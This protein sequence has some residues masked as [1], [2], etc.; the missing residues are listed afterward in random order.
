MADTF[1]PATGRKIPQ[2]PVVTKSVEFT[3]PSNTT[4]YTGGDAIAPVTVAITGATNASPAVITAASHGLSTGDRV[5]I[6]AVG[7]NTAMNGDWVVT[8]LTSGTFKIS[9]EAGYLTGTFVAGNGAYTSGGTIQKMLRLADVVSVDGG[10]GEIQKIRLTMGDAGVTTAT[11]RFR[12][13]NSPISQIADNAAFTLL[14]A[15]RA[16]QV[17]DVSPTTVLTEGSG[18]NSAVVT[19]VPSPAIP[20]ECDSSRRDL[21]IQMT[22]V[23]T[24]T[25]ASAETIRIEVT[26]RDKS[27]PSPVVVK[28]TT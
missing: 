2:S 10:A 8:V 12:F 3:R 27:A 18:S 17:A 13:Y 26:I 19:H 5:T 21:F 23:G 4:Q 1:D 6:A 25:P 22:A 7:G 24:Y 16:K 20:F 14:Y 9:T 15:N 28:S 11:F